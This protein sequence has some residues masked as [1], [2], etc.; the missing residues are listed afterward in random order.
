MNTAC[1]GR[2]ECV[3]NHPLFYFSQLGDREGAVLRQGN[4]HSADCGMNFIDPFVERYLKMAVRLLFRAD[5]AFANPEIHEYLESESVDYA[6]RLPT[7]EVLQREIAH[8]LVPPTEWS[9]RKPIV[10]Y[11]DFG[12]QAKSWSV[13]RRLVARV[14]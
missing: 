8:L 10:L 14:E 11:H 7:N 6:I 2:F 13:S 9:S 1:N 5:A 3:C 4:V 12:Y